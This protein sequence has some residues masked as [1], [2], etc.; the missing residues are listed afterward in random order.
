M[1]SKVNEIR[2]SYRERISVANSPVIRSSKDA[3]EL[4]YKNWNKDTIGL[5]ETFKVMLLNNAN[6]VKGIYP[7]STGG[8]TGTMVDIRILFAI[9]IKTL[10]VG[11]ILSHNHPSSKLKPSETDISLTRKIRRAAELLDVKVLDHVILTPEGSYYSFA[12]QG[13]L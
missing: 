5:Q 7:L 9:V 13:D 6:K 10:T 2:I 11:I 4:L 3:A 8:I 1:N 12:D